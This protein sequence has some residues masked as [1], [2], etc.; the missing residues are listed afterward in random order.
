MHMMFRGK[1]LKTMWIY[2]SVQVIRLGWFVNLWNCVG[3]NVR[4]LPFWEINWKACLQNNSSDFVCLLVCSSKQLARLNRY[5]LVSAHLKKVLP[6]RYEQM[7]YA[8]S[9]WQGI[10]ATSI[11]WFGCTGLFQIIE[12]WLLFTKVIWL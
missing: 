4:I 7:F 12:H 10:Y 2:N 11:N 6:V 8:D 9:I 3:R 1:C 5:L